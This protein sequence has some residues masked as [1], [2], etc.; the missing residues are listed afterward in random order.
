M[1]I[2][3]FGGPSSWDGAWYSRHRLTAGLARRNRVFLVEAPIEVR[4]VLRHPMSV[5]R[6][7]QVAKDSQGA[8]RYTSPAWLP[9]VYQPAWL[10]S[11]LSSARFGSLQRALRQENALPAVYYMWHPDH[12]P[13]VRRLVGN[14]L[15]YHCYDRYDR[16]TDAGSGVQ[17]REGA[18]V[19]RAALCVAAS[20]ELGE[21][22]TK[23]GARQVVVLR[24]GVDV[25]SF[26][27]GVPPHAALEAIPRPRLG[28]V[29]SL[30]DAVDVETL[31]RIARE[32]P[33][34]SLVIVGKSSFTTREKELTF[35]EL[36][37]LPN[38]HCLGFRPRSEIPSWINGFDVTLTCY[39]L[40]TWAP[41]N[42]PLKMYEYLACGLPVVSSDITAARELGDLVACADGP[43]SWVPTIERVL[44]DNGPRQIERRAAFGRENN[45]EHRVAELHDMLLDVAAGAG[46][47]RSASDEADEITH[48]N[49][50]K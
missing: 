4:R 16:Y 22:L 43:D 36:S 9:E 32:R 19:R 2:V 12:E 38:V 47:A 30:S 14:P 44:A 50:L 41:Y 3:M 10:R 18:L 39:D 5:W 20:V 46:A 1:N 37:G 34:W 29:A 23:L 25:T 28:L 33:S 24:H 7:A 17:D 26:K 11:V 48:Y 35:R 8:F 45:W 6:G 49:A 42:Q 15:V 31:V 27:P 13:A 40:K 21:Y